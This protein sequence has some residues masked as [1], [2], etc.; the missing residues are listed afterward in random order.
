MPTGG[1][2]LGFCLKKG[3]YVG[4]GRHP[5][6]GVTGRRKLYENLNDRNHPA[7]L[8]NKGPGG[9]NIAF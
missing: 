4:R 7:R 2:R 9:C 5:I 8:V 3:E 6:H 1:G